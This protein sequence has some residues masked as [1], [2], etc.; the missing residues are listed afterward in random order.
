MFNFRF[1]WVFG[2]LFSQMSVLT[3]ER[4]QA[5]SVVQI[6]GDFERGFTLMKNGKP[7]LIHGAGGSDYFD[8]MAETGGNAIRTWGVG[9]DTEAM[10]DRAHANG[11][12][13]TIGLWLGHERHGFDYSDEVQLERQRKEVEEAVRKFK[14]HPALLT[15]GL[16]NEMEGIQ[17][18]GDSPVIW[19]EVNV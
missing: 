6:Q 15:W 9:A 1:V 5:A 8:V 17:N 2:I 19:K 16:G 14:D 12:A 18:R 4:S 10:L 13:V 3:L 7:F 11:I